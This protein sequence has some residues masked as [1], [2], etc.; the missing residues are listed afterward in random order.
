MGK[1]SPVKMGDRT[2][3]PG[4]EAALRTK[5]AHPVDIGVITEF[6]S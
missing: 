1:K 5:T 4:V 6:G 2:I 3:L